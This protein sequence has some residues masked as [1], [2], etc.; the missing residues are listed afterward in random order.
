[1]VFWVS[2]VEPLLALPRSLLLQGPGPG[3]AR[4]GSQ[5][6]SIKDVSVTGEVK[7]PGDPSTCSQDG[8]LAAKPGV[9]KQSWAWPSPQGSLEVE[10]LPLGAPA[11]PSS[12]GQDPTV[13]RRLSPCAPFGEHL[14][15][16]LLGDEE[17]V[18]RPAAGLAS[19]DSL[20]QSLAGPGD[21]SVP[22][23]LLSPRLSPAARAPLGRPP[24][25]RARRRAGFQ[26]RL[27]RTPFSVPA[28]GLR[29]WTPKR[30]RRDTGRAPR[31]LI[32]RGCGRGITSSCPPPTPI[33]APAA[34]REAG[35]R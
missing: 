16:P 28:P 14:T 1:M 3:L 23:S 8:L 9:A 11:P 21:P 5:E 19:Q 34:A 31:K 25:C 7:D 13:P 4:V 24:R 10:F 18:V 20:S 12:T 2:M 32:P 30:G 6:P 33:P 27:I 35:E 17:V 15:A 22:P 29:R 26:T